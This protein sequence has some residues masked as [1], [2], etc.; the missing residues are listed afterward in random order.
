MRNGGRAYRR[1]M[2]RKKFEQRRRFLLEVGQYYYKPS[3]GWLSENRYYIKHPKNSN[4]EQY[5]KKYSSRVARR[6]KNDEDLFGRKGNKYRRVIDY[7]WEV[8]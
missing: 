7:V 4:Q 5:W 2:R 3:L 6:K 8:Y 1:Y